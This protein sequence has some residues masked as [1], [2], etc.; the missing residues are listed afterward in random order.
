MNLKPW[1]ALLRA[2]LKLCE[3]LLAHVI[4]G[5]KSKGIPKRKVRKSS[6]FLN[7]TLETTVRK[8]TGAG[9]MVRS[10]GCFDDLSLRPR[11]N[12]RES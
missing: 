6:C 4:T 9:E 2:L 3:T 5:S 7:V 12:V 8:K 1:L 10:V 11:G